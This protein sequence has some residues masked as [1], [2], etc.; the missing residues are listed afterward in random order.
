[1]ISTGGS[2]PKWIWFAAK[3]TLVLQI[4]LFAETNF[5]EVEDSRIAIALM[6]AYGDKGA[7]I[8]FKHFHGPDVEVPAFRA[9]FKPFRI[10]PFTIY[11]QSR[12]IKEAFENK[13]MA[14]DLEAAL[15][16]LRAILS[17]R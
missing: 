3:L 8:A 17:A 14:E 9:S 5:E 16:S 7:A 13:R 10:N 11:L 15:T 2:P 4:V 12:Y 6:A 1:M